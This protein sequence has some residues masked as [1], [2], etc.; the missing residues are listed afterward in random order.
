M[1]RSQLRLFEVAILLFLL[2][3]SFQTPG[4][5]A[6]CDEKVTAAVR[7][8]SHH[9]WRPPFGLERI[10]QPLKVVVEF[11]P[12]E[13]PYREYSLASYVGGKEN[14]RQMLAL[15]RR[16]DSGPTPPFIGQASFEIRP[17]EL[18]VFG[19]C[20][21]QGESVEIARVRLDPAGLEA[22]AIARPEQVVN[23]VDLGTILVPHD[24]LLL[25]PGQKTLVDVAAIDR[26]R[27]VARAQMT[28]W[29]E[30]SPQG[31]VSAQIEMPKG[32]RVVSQLTLPSAG[33]AA[34][35]DTLRLALLDAGGKELWQ[36]KI[37]TMRVTQAPKWPV[38]GAVEAR[39]RY[40]APVSVRDPKTGSL[41]TIDYATAWK[42][43]F[44]DVVVFLPNGSR[45]VFW[46][47]S[48]YIPFW[49]SRYNTGVSY[50]WA[51][52]VPPPDGFTDS[53]EPL[54]DKELRYGRVEIVESTAARIHVR[55]TYQSNDFNYK[56]WGD[57]PS[58]DFYFYPDGYGTRVL[59]LR[60]AP[61][62]RYEVLEYIV[63]TDAVERMLSS[64]TRTI[65][66]VRRSRS[67]QPPAAVETEWVA[68]LSVTG[69]WP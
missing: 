41:S 31:K 29:F 25:G 10:G 49:A 34:E 44:K 26:S 21:F 67:D 65:T 24:W 69:R 5:A 6:D 66:T 52:T 9:P 16:P 28:A 36:K 57:S 30:S 8:P 48:S 4:Q 51:E 55:W 14:A 47:G 37:P 64:R 23:P 40:D 7:F 1:I 20:R 56:V 17:E 61:G 11:K 60:S 22:D 3:S 42:P 15:S 53:V 63:L 35:R 12:A 43:E 45:F 2:S 59:T 50:E 38:F 33:A 13:R 27:D 68:G 46:R 54:M 39:L 18:V 32:K 58:E 62:A 19:K